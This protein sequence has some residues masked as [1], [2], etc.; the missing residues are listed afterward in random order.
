VRARRAATLA[1]AA[2]AAWLAAPHARAYRTTQDSASS[3]AG[4]IHGPV[5]WDVT[6]VPYAV[7]RAASDDLT[8]DQVT[9]A[10]DLAF[11]T[12]TGPSCSAL[13]VTDVGPT[14]VR[15][16][17][18]DGTNVVVWEETGWTTFG[19]PASAIGVTQTELAGSAGGT[20]SITGADMQLNGEGYTWV[21]EGGMMG[22]T[23]VDVQSVVTHES[24]HY[25]GLLHPC[26]A[27]GFDG[28]PVCG[29]LLDPGAAP[30]MYPAYTGMGQRTLEADDVD[31]ICF[32]YPRAGCETT[33]C[34]DGE[35]CDGAEHCVAVTPPPG[36]CCA[37]SGARGS[38]AAPLALAACALALAG[39]ARRRR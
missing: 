34:A 10:I 11:A 22:S 28:A 32:L 27:T 5:A 8:L 21:L 30:T 12:W 2:L 33:R 14:D 16:R 24:G 38:G 18:H 13:A 31:G 4:G 26:E 19:F 35:R 3:A 1:L 20:W 6:P 39:G 23:T 36:G 7:N 17:P 29:P 25:L 9:P 15:A 37:A